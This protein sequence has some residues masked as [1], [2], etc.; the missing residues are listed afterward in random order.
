MLE[1]LPFSSSLFITLTAQIRG[2]DKRLFCSA[3]EHSGNVELPQ[4]ICSK[5]T[6]R[7]YVPKFQNSN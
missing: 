1:H 2:W 3:M 6:G 5:G 7:N 4:A